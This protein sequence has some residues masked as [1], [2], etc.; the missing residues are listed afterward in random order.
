LPQDAT[1]ELVAGLLAQAH[2]LAVSALFS[3]PLHP[4]VS[5]L[6]SEWHATI[7]PEKTISLDSANG[8]GLWFPLFPNRLRNR[9][10]EATLR[11]LPVTGF[12]HCF[13]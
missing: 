12:A 2:A 5:S 10:H 7:L 1:S 11:D 13:Q 6:F 3:D 8:S 9:L 4:P